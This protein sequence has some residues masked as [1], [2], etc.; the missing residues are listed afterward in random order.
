[1]DKYVCR[2]SAVDSTDICPLDKLARSQFE[3][4]TICPI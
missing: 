3:D 2:S 1:M 4:G